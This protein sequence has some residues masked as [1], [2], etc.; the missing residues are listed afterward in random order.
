MAAPFDLQAIREAA[1]ESSCY[2]VGHPV[3]GTPGTPGADRARWAC[4]NIS[5]RSVGLPPATPE[6]IPGQ[7]RTAT[8]SLRDLGLSDEAI[9]QLARDEL[10]RGEIG[11]GVASLAEMRS[12]SAPIFATGAIR[13]E[14][15]A[16]ALIA[17]GDLRLGPEAFQSPDARAALAMGLQMALQASA[18]PTGGNMSSAWFGLGGSAPGF[19]FPITGFG[20]TIPQFPV[21][22]DAV[23]GGGLLGT[24]GGLLNTGLQLFGANQQAN[25]QEDLLKLQLQI[26]QAN[27]MA[28]QQSFLPG[29]GAA[30]LPAILGGIGTGVGTGAVAAG[31][32][33]LQSLFTGGGGMGCG[34]S[35]PPVQ[36]PSLF[37][38]N[39]CGKMSLPARQQ[40]IG[41]DG[42]LYIV[43]SL[44]KATRGSREQ[45][46]MRRL[47][48]QNGFTVTRAGGRSS[49][50]SRRRPR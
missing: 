37:R 19:S 21:S 10:T 15:L 32:G 4:L 1:A 41:P 22:V 9:V 7:I 16:R 43:A 28:A 29:L 39:A 45:S 26:A 11:L 20:G 27:A 33:M 12:M 23:G 13:Q 25:A 49:R 17:S 44:G 3:W 47:A 50:R 46:T 35:R 5:R 42:S 40:V 36:A 24:F 2:P 18:S 14:D 30:T 6:A 34:V 8:E 31:M 48:R 38:T